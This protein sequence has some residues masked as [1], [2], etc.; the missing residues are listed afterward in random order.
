MIDSPRVVGVD[1]GGTKILAGV[2]DAEGV[3][4]SRFWLS[5]LDLQDQPEALLQRIAEAG[6]EAAREAGV[7]W[8]RVAAGGVGI[9]GP[10]D[11]TRWIVAVAPNLGWENLPARPLLEEL[12]AGPSVFLEN[13]VR[14]A[15][16]AEYRSGAEPRGRSLLAVFVGTGVGGG[17]IVDGRLYHGTRGG[18]G[19]IGH[20]VI[21]A[22]G[23]LCGCGRRGCLEAL[24][25]RGAI[26]R[27]VLRAIKRGRSTVLQAVFEQGAEV[28]T[29][30][31]LALA[32]EQD[33]AVAVAAA[34]KSARAV[35]L[36][37]GSVANL[38][39]PDVVVLGGGIVEGAGDAYVRWVGKVAQGQMLSE[40]AR[41]IPIVAATLGDDAGLLGA[42]FTAFDG[43]QQREEV[44]RTV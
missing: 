24:A 38:L 10:L 17:L 26:T 22:G 1:L 20:M 9:P 25:A 27:E 3:V 14:A 18:A 16:L 15:A 12:F 4:L 13:D 33:D 5:S 41:G 23:P 2:V 19:E 21:Q 6:R 8:S 35:G 37:V 42:A 31:D 34:R 30:R 39:D 36:A 44:V 43:L 32:I 29:S 11:A 7:E 28:V 40:A